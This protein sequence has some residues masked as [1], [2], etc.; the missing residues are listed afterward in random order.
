MPSIQ[1]ALKYAATATDSSGTPTAWANLANSKALDGAVAVFSDGTGVAWNHGGPG[2]ALT[3]FG[4]GLPTNAI[5]DGIQLVVTHWGTLVNQ[6]TIALQ[7]ITGAVSK[8]SGI[9]LSLNGFVLGGPTDLWGAPSITPAMLNSTSFGVNVSTTNTHDPADASY[10]IDA[11]SVVVYYHIGLVA[12]PNDVP[13]REVYKV[14]NAA[15]QYLGNFPKVSTALKLAQDINSLGSQITVNVPINSDVS[16]QATDIYT[17]EDLSANYTTED[18]LGNY[19]TEGQIPIVSAAFQGIDTL[20]KNGNIVECWFYNYWYPNGKCMFVGKIRRWEADFGGDGTQGDSVNIKLYSTSYDMDN[21]VARGAPFAYT[22][23]QS[24][25]LSNSHVNLQTQDKGAGWVRAGQTV[26]PAAAN[27]GA[28]NLLLNGAADVTINIYTVPNGGTLLGSGTLSVNTGGT[29]TV[30]QLATA[31]LITTTPGTQY[32]IEVLVGPGQNIDLYYQST[33]VYAGGQAYQNSYGGSGGG[34]YFLSGGDLYFVT[35][36]GTASTTATFTAQDPSTGMLE[37]ILTDYALRGGSATWMASTIDATGLTLTYTF[38]VQTIYEALQAILSLAPNGF[39]YYVDIGQQVVYFKNASTTPDF[40]LQK[41]VDVNA[42][43]LIN[44][45]ESSVNQLL[46]TGGPAPTQNLYKL[47]QSSKSIAAFGVLL[48]RKTDNRVT[49]PAT[50][51]AIGVSEIA[52]LSGEQYQ[53]TIT[54]VATKRLDITLLVPGKVVGFR[55]YGSFVDTILA[56]IVHRDWQAEQV[57]LTLGVLPKRLSFSYE[58]TTRQ[59]TAS[60]TQ[61]NPSTPS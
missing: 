22:N 41:G 38:S 44:T 46:F 11:V 48:D 10:S 25:V 53:T 47:Y 59:L 17:V 5:I 36:S 24:Q 37:P 57:V 9:G 2:V 56:Q 60:Q 26:T 52:E 58:Q 1:T 34:G 13:I 19:T 55:G 28:V 33:D 27:F 35:G 32:F 16:N 30:V 12:T 23:D 40:L 18:A 3:N 45:T 20:I 43:T 4:M 50:A 7:N 14:Y 39:Y 6:P 54:I 61:N 42:L 15:G 51:D 21:Y 8:L 49:I 31:N 29:P